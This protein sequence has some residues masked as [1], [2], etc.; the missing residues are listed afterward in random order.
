M[1][2]LSFSKN[3]RIPRIRHRIDTV[4]SLMVKAQMSTG[5]SF[6]RILDGYFLKEIGRTKD[7]H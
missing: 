2:R 3:D 4:A 5:F 1:S 7:L 6:N